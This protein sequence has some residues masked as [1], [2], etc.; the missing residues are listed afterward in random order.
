MPES[1]KKSR[2]FERLEAAAR[3]S[4]QQVRDISGDPDV[5][6]FQA[7]VTA[8]SSLPVAA[9]SL[10][11]IEESHQLAR[12]I[13]NQVQSRV[14][15]GSPRDYEPGSNPD[16]SPDVSPHQGQTQF[17]SGSEPVHFTSPSPLHGV[18]ESLTSGE[19]A[20]ILGLWGVRAF[21]A[22]SQTLLITQQ[23]LARQTQVSVSTVKR[24][25]WKLQRAGLLGIT[26]QARY[27]NGGAS[28]AY[29][30]GFRDVLLGAMN[31]VRPRFE[32]GSIQ[33]HAKSTAPSYNSSSLSSSLEDK[34][35]LQ[36]LV[37]DGP[38]AT[39][40]PQVITSNCPPK[41]NAADKIQRVLDQAA[42]CVEER[43]R[44]GKPY[45]S[46]VG[47]LIACLRQGYCTPPLGWKSR[48]ELALEEEL[49]EAKRQA[50]LA[51]ALLAER[52]T[53]AAA[54]LTDRQRRWLT[55]QV[56]RILPTSLPKDKELEL[57]EQKWRQVLQGFV[58]RGEAVPEERVRERR[59]PKSTAE[60]TEVGEPLQARSLAEC[61][62][63]F[64]L[65]DA[66]ACWERL[67]SGERAEW[68]ARAQ[69]RKA[70]DDAAQHLSDERVALLLLADSL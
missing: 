50:I 11:A 28:Y 25:L 13:G 6:F 67:P 57:L 70:S 19:A 3:A 8:T 65:A 59:G 26:R 44:Q 63:A 1:R 10:D 49:A 60:G 37:Y 33:A 7:F 43:R 47:F 12:C 4:L 58:E 46:E 14:E 56:R 51:E 30:A 36:S 23:E 35:L 31:R 9:K 16:Q 48:E 21:P 22:E 62:E 53:T 27:R 41:L 18:V 42:A 64:R 17:E 61:A 68:L 55:E 34:E 66:Q 29:L 24:T 38:W 5:S 45:E 54:R 2:E 39:L 40:D 32:T 69:A 20:A 52:V 15:H